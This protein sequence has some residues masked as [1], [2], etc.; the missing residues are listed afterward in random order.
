MKS[1]NGYIS[2]QY[3]MA[4]VANEVN[5]L[6]HQIRSAFETIEKIKKKVTGNKVP[7][8]PGMHE[9]PGFADALRDCED[10]LHTVQGYSNAM[11]RWAGKT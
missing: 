7:G 3:S 1:F 4:H 6:S 10:T 2:E 5:T 11:R 9:V 8:H